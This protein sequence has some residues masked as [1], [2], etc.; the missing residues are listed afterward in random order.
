MNA[1]DAT[2][3]FHELAYQ[4][5][6][7]HP[8][9]KIEAA[10][11]VGRGSHTSDVGAGVLAPLGGA[12]KTAVESLKGAVPKTLEEANPLNVRGAFGKTETKFAPSRAAQ[13]M[14]HNVDETGRL[15]AFAGYLEQGFDPAAAAEKA[16]AMRMDPDKLTGFEKE[17]MRRLV[18]NYSW[19]RTS[20][21]GMVGEIAQKPG[22]AVG[23]SIRATNELRQKEGLI[24]DYV[25]EGLALP[26]RPRP[27][28]PIRRPTC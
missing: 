7:T 26:C 16:K 25:G 28:R 24:P 17:W 21:P 4:F 8:A 15:A 13:E 3:K 23:T 9:D 20:V 19:L 14:M 2:K 10:G 11:I 1:A 27:R 22:G 18:P 12:K 6:I 5:G